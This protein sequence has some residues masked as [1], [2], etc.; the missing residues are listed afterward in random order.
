M[1]TRYEYYRDGGDDGRK[2]TGSY[3]AQTF[4]PQI[5]HAIEYI[6]FVGA[7]SGAPGNLEVKIRPVDGEGKPT[8]EPLCSGSV[9]VNGWSTDLTW[10][11]VTLGD[12]ANLYADTQY[13]MT[14][15]CTEGDDA[16]YITWWNDHTSPA[17]TRG[18]DYDSLDGIS[19]SAWFGCDFYFEEYGGEL[20]MEEKK[21]AIISEIWNW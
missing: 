9:N 1:A 2:V 14:L 13:A 10:F 20:I 12:G 4:T 19:W 5:S 11:T 8:G 15:H 6:K 7:R 17:Y 16:N 21:A 18:R 3:W